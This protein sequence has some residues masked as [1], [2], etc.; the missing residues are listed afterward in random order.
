M[1]KRPR[2]RQKNKKSVPAWLGDEPRRRIPYTT[3]RDF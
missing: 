2:I 3:D 1:D